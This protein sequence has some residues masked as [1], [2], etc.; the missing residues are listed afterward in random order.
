MTDTD[1]DFEIDP[2]DRVLEIGRNVLKSLEDQQLL[3]DNLHG[4][5]KVSLLQNS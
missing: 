4:S 1:S 3:K 5:I 2:C